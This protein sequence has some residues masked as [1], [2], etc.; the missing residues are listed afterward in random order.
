M[1]AVRNELKSIAIEVNDLLTRYIKIH[2]DVFKFSWRRIIPLP[3]VFKSIDFN[4]VHA[5]AKQ[6]LSE[7]EVCNERINNLIESTT[8]KESRFAHFLSEYSMA[9]IETVSLLREILYQLYLK[10]QNLNEYSISEYNKGCDLYKK[11]VNKYHSMGS[12]LNELYAELNQFESKSSEQITSGIEPRKDLSEEETKKIEEEFEKYG[13]EHGIKS[14]FVIEELFE[15]GDSPDGMLSRISHQPQIIEVLQKYGEEPNEIR[16]I[17]WK[18]MASGAGEYVAQSVI[19]NP[20]LLSEYL[21]MKAEGVS[22][23]DI[24]FKFIETLGGS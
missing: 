20:K 4:D 22:D 11:A 21:R 3:F 15:Q 14:S 24:A 8:K 19:E 23:M 10:S 7:L 16:D 9:L 5:Q 1:S 12:R 13:Q 6:I 18:L 2:N 17:Y